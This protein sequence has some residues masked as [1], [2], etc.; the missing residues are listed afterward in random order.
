MDRE[1]DS[2]PSKA[3]EIKSEGTTPHSRLKGVKA[4][5]H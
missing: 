2:P 5:Q 4:A 3:E 1:F